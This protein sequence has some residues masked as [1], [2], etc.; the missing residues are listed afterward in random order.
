[1]FENKC[2]FVIVSDER[3]GFCIMKA[4]DEL[5]KELDKL[6]I[7]ST[8]MSKLP[9]SDDVSECKKRIEDLLND[10]THMTIVLAYTELIA[11]LLE[12]I[13]LRHFSRKDK[14]V[15]KLINILNI[16]QRL[17]LVYALGLVNK[18]TL[19]DINLMIDI[20]NALFH[21][22][23]KTFESVGVCNICKRLSTAKG[24]KITAKNSFK[25]YGK[26]VLVQLLCLLDAME[27]KKEQELKL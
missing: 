13:L 4:T 18:T 15:Q 2:F 11:M 12:R 7:I 9:D 1:M 17:R 22:L 3:H 27:L 23:P 10:K 6:K 26:T 24:Q 21:G 20:R 14:E 19:K 25:V 5:E 8:F 16:P